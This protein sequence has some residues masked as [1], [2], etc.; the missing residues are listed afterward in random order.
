[1][2]SKNH[3]L[4]ND[5]ITKMIQL[6]ETNKMRNGVMI[7]GKTG[8]G[9]TAVWETLKDAIIQVSK[10]PKNKNTDFKSIKSFIVNPKS[11]SYA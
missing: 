4:K 5:L 11:L 7:V 1:M 10:D 8:V 2:L 9:K 3:Q 6:N